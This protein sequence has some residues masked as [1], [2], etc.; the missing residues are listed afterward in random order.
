M[1]DNNNWFYGCI[2]YRVRRLVRCAYDPVNG[3]T[4]LYQRKRIVISVPTSIAWQRP[5]RVA[6]MT[7]DCWHYRPLTVAIG[8]MP[9]QSVPVNCDSTTNEATTV[10]IGLRLKANFCAHISVHVVPRLT[11]WVSTVCYVG[12][13]L[14]VSR[15]GQDLTCRTTCWQGPASK[16]GSQWLRNPETISLL[17]RKGWM[18]YPWL[19]WESAH[20]SRRMQTLLA[21]SFRPMTSVTIAAAAERDAHLKHIKYTKIKAAYDFVP[22]A[23]ETPGTIHTE[24]TAEDGRARQLP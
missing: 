24:G 9:C 22:V 10:A 6:L 2:D 13:V 16:M 4:I 11:L 5:Q 21:S 17:M 15:D 20:A 8:S 23:I 7:S 19:H 12:I 14:V 1:S 3:N 18:V